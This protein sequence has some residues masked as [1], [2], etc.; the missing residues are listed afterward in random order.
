LQ[1][2]ETFTALNGLRFFAALCV[3]IFHYAPRAEGYSRVPVVVKN[4]INEGP[5]AVG[6]FFILSGFVLAYRH[7]QSGVRVRTATTFYW[8]RFV[9]LYPAYLLAFLLFIPMAVQQDLSNTSSPPA[10]RHTFILSAVLSCLMLQAWTPLAQAWN[11]P[12]WSLSVE[13]FMY[14]TFPFV[15]A[16]LIKLSRRKTIFA[17]LASWLIPSGIACVYEAHRID[18][19]VWRA[20]ITNNPLLWMSLFVMGI[21]ATRMLP[22]WSDV[23]TSTANIISSAVFVALILLAL[24]WP[25]AW[26]DIFVTGGIAPVLAALIVCFTRT[27]GW[28]TKAIGASFFNR[29]GEASY[30]VYILQ[31]PVWHY[32][33]ELTNHMRRIPAQT[34]IVAT[35]QM[36]AFVPVL[37]LTAMVTHRFLES[38]LRG[39]LEKRGRTLFR[40]EAPQ[41]RSSIESTPTTPETAESF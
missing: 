26:S 15:G 35:W 38:P 5:A 3:V 14:L 2:S 13:A 24:L 11:G 6:F 16:R 32:W 18:G 20:Y 9:R 37:I 4:L 7:L 12:S 33:Q 22:A 1:K 8:A 36:V 40:P 19:S 41:Q 25:R 27:S 21:C 23:R 34:G 10:G 30:S 31:V 28:I 17:F 39:W 29:L